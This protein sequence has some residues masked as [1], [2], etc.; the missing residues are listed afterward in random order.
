MASETRTFYV[1]V[2]AQRADF[3][4]ALVSKLVRRGFNVGAL[5]RQ[6]ITEAEDNPAVVVA[7]SLMRTP[8]NAVEQK[9]YTAIGVHGEVTDVIKQIKGKFWG[10]IVS[11]AENC[12]WNVG[13]MSLRAEEEDQAQKA[14]K[15]N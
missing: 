11:A 8:K 4:E 15:V 9:E 2:V 3:A 12:T 1:W 13:N 6:L 14:R 7:M 10:I 5:G